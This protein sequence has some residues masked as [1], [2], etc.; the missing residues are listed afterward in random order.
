[1]LFTLLFIKLLLETTA[2]NPWYLNPL[3]Q[4]T[5]AYKQA[6][7]AHYGP[8]E[9]ADL[10][11]SEFTYI[12]DTCGPLF[13][14]KFKSRLPR[15]MYLLGSLAYVQEHVPL[16][17][18]TFVCYGPLFRGMRQAKGEWSVLLERYSERAVVVRPAAAKKEKLYQIKPYTCEHIQNLKIDFLPGTLGPWGQGSVLRTCC[19]EPALSASH[20]RKE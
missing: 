11:I 14:C 3:R 5:S 2:L 4:I 1:M 19:H 16:T 17:E 12:M 18:D 7:V 10:C 6:C 9:E 20:R 15:S 13:L 8:G